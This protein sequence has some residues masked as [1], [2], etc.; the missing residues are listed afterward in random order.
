[1]LRDILLFFIFGIN[2]VILFF[3]IKFKDTME[4]TPKLVNNVSKIL[5]SF[6]PKS[7]ATTIEAIN[8]ANETICVENNGILWPGYKKKILGTEIDIPEMKVC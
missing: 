8:K 3:V 6:D 7:L 2:V 5:N 4:K 1:M